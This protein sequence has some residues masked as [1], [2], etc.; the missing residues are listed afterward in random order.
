MCN[1]RLDEDGNPKAVYE[2]GELPPQA[3]L[4][5]L[6]DRHRFI[7]HLRGIEATSPHPAGT[8]GL[9]QNGRGDIGGPGIY[10]H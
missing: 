10:G 2:F 3:C 6:S 5:H 4:C 7:C 8:S 9:L 1:L